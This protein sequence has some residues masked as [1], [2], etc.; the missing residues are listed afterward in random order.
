M[1]ESRPAP[2]RRARALMGVVAASALIYPLL[3]CAVQLL[4]AQLVTVDV[5]A[6]VGW[7]ALAVLCSVALVA[8]VRWGA[9]RRFLSPWLLFGL[10]PPAVYELWLTWPLLTK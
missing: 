1:A 9:D 8:V 10:A 6:V 3:M 5:G 7:L 4:F 2:E